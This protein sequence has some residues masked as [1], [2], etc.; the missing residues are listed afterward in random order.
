M[1]GFEIAALIVALIA[2]VCIGAL[3]IVL[4]NMV[5]TLMQ[6]QST[7]D[8]LHSE[9]VPLLQ[10]LRR[11]VADTDAEIA[12]VEGVLDVAEAASAQVHAAS[13]LARRALINPVIRVAAMVA[14]TRAG[15]RELTPDGVRARRQRRAIRHQRELRIASKQLIA[16]G[17]SR[18]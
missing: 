10:D 9:T 3:L 14:G 11:L 13:S 5:R 4:S 15:V 18:D 7:V 16:E 8:Q 6:L 12:R 17:A 1:S 2:A